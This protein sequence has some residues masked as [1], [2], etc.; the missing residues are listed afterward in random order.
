[1][2]IRRL[3]TVSLDELLITFNSAFADYIIP[4]KLDK[5]QLLF[6][7]KSESID[8]NWSL[9]AFHNNSLIGVILHGL[10][11][12]NG[13]H[14]MYNAGTGV[15]PYYRGQGIVKKSYDHIL[16]QLGDNNIQC[17]KLEV[18]STNFPA[19]R[20]Y[21]KIGFETQRKLL[22]F[23]GTLKMKNLVSEYQIKNLSRFN[24]DEFLPFWDI[25]PSWQNSVEALEAT[26]ETLVIL[27]ALLNSRVIGY[28]IYN[29]YTIKIYQLS[30]SKEHRRK[31]VATQLISELR[32]LDKQKIITCNNVDEASVPMKLFFEKMGIA[33][34]IQQLEMIRTN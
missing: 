8:L 11:S 23:G 18:I 12:I 10:R 7:I 24:W 29:P 3:N 26:K 2:D 22:C 30:V 4:F 5:D 15:L 32:Q 31:G 6:K 20:A 25:K 1:M 33:E 21:E 34:R 13:K 9:G 28:L 19:I 17:V 27:G 14:E 16:P